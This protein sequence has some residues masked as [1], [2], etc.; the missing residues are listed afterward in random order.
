[1][2]S[3]KRKKE[4]FY[5][6]KMNTFFKEEYLFVLKI[7]L[8]LFI[9][10]I[11][12]FSLE[13]I[14]TKFRKNTIVDY[15]YIGEGNASLIQTK[16]GKN[17]LIDSGDGGEER[18]NSGEKIL[19][20]YLLFNKIHKIDEIY[21][22]HLDKDHFGGAESIVKNL[23]V[24]KVY[25]PYGYINDES[26]AKFKKICIRKH[27]EINEVYLDC[28]K[29][30]EENIYLS[31]LWPD[32]WKKDI[33]KVKKEIA[34]KESKE[35]NNNSLV[36][37]LDIYGK[38]ILFPGDIEKETEYKI[39]KKYIKNELKSD[40]LLSPHHGSKTSSSDIFLEK[41]NPKTVIISCGK[42]NIFKHPNKDVLEKYIKR[43]INVYR[44]DYDGLV[45]LK[46]DINGKM[47]EQKYKK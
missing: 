20:P 24:K 10:F 23:N 27:I 45:R 13:N 28:K 34:E 12:I 39:S 40:V 17:I 47:K 6:K 26:F 9:L 16:K 22:T 32:K 35:K 4:K 14:K 15:I 46:I 41:V 30:I 19:L 37:K 1:M 29:Q 5:L 3:L 44:T 8:I 25:I 7:F 38:K 31:I 18:Y 33:N 11:C 42:N 2:E 43:N 21:I 36:I